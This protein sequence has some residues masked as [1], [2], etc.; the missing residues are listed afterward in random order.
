MTDYT[1]TWANLPESE[2]DLGHLSPAAPVRK[3]W[4]KKK[5]YTLV[6]GALAAVL[7]PTAA[8]A[9]VNIFGFG[10][11]DGA[12]ATTQNL[13]IDSGTAQLTGSLTPGNTVGAK[14]NVHNPND[15]PVT[16]TA[17]ILKN[18]SLT[19]TAKAPAGPGDQDSCNATV[20]PVG[21][22]T[23]Y[24]GSS[25]AGTKQAISENVVI[26]AGQSR[27]VTVPAAVKQDAAGTALC[28]VHADFAVV[29]QTAS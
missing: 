24:P 7:I 14:A 8:W 1:S 4:S 2:A 20:H 29:A 5:K 3:G 17:I 23:T 10:S 21:T 26:P 11:F 13:T 28:A 9:A 27:Q 18:S 25:D 6:G 16:V 15:F 22:A 19:A 12:A